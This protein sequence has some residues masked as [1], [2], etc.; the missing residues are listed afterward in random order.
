MN[1]TLEVKIVQGSTGYVGEVLIPFSIVP[2]FKTTIDEGK[3][4]AMAI[5][6]ADAERAGGLKRVQAAN[7]PHFVEDY[8]TKSA[9]MPQ[10]YFN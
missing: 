10:Y 7:V 9:R 5:V 4:I 3:P 8:K 2:E 6:C 1:S